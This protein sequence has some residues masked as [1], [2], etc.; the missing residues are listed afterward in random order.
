MVSPLSQCSNCKAVFE[1]KTISISGTV[2]NLVLENNTERCPYCGGIAK[3]LD[4]TFNVV[5]DAFEV[6]RAPNLTK[7]KYSRFASLIEEAQSKNMKSDELLKRANSIDPE[8]G[9]AV[10]AIK[11][12][13]PKAGVALLILVAVLKTCSFDVNVDV[14]IN[15]LIGQVIQK[16]P[17]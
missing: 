8:L 7:E 2:T 17:K 11:A 16:Q 10:A 5:R 3:T 6:I 15:K 14:D 9:K 1:S 13:G 12:V 4:G